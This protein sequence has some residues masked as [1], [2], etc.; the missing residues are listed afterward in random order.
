M[1]WGPRGD[2]T[3]SW[4]LRQNSSRKA[5]EMSLFT[6]PH[7]PWR[8]TLT[9]FLTNLAA[10]HWGICRRDSGSS[11]HTQSDVLQRRQSCLCRGGLN[12]TT[13][14]PELTQVIPAEIISLPT[15]RITRI[16][17]FYAPMLGDV[18]Y[19]G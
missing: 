7:A 14:S 1:L 9:L 17:T 18:C 16:N 4:G 8:V 2:P 11:S 13:N 5:D 15:Y 10:H 3:T 12:I 19:S 6:E